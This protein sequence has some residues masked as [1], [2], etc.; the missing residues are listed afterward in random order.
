LAGSA[1]LSPGQNGSYTFT[2]TGGPK[3]ATITPSAGGTIN[4]VAARLQSADGSVEYDVQFWDT[5]GGGAVSASL[6]NGNYRLFL[7]P[8]GDAGGSI[9]FGLALT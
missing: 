1:S 4:L 2:V 7:D 3:T 9:S 8:V 6:P 5:S